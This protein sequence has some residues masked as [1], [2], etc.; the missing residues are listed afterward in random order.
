MKFLEVDSF[1][2]PKAGHDAATFC[3]EINAEVTLLNHSWRSSRRKEA[4][5]LFFR[6]SLLTSAATLFL[7]EMVSAG[8]DREHGAVTFHAE[9]F[10][11]LCLS[12]ILTVLSDARA[13]A[14]GDINGGGG[15]RRDVRL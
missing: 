11:A 14:G 9:E 4:P 7:G 2:V 15:V 13:L 3:A 5:I 12:Q 10:H 1:A 8:L 6:V